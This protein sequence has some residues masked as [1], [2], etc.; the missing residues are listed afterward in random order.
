[1]TDSSMYLLNYVRD[2][3]ICCRVL[4]NDMSTQ[5]L[6]ESDSFVWVDENLK[7]MWERK[8]YRWTG[9]EYFMAVPCS[10]YAE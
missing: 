6:C 1:M 4:Q 9:R 3:V 2:F 5:F 8:S 7:L 10:V